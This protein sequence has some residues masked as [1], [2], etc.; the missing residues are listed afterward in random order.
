MHSTNSEVDKL[1]GKYGFYNIS[2]PDI[3]E[4]ETELLQLMENLEKMDKT[5]PKLRKQNQYD[6]WFAE[7]TELFYKYW[8]TMAFIEHY[9]YL[10]DAFIKNLK[11]PK[12]NLE[13]QKMLISVDEGPHYRF[14]NFKNLLWDY[15]H[16]WDL[17]PEVKQIIS[18][19]ERF[20]NV[21]NL[22]KQIRCSHD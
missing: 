2:L 14:I 6:I 8:Q 20:E 4:T 19:D 18:N 5:N 3:P 22:Y 17:L 9:G 13:L 15:L 10:S 21:L 7:H 11:Q 1:I 12:Q 16:R